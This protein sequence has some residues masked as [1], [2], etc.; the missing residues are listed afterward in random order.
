ML[1]RFCELYCVMSLV[2]V[3]AMFYS[4]DSNDI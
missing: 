2:N 4:K 1:F 3:K